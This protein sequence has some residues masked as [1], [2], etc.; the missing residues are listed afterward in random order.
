MYG[1]PALNLVNILVG[2]H[3]DL[4]QFQ[5]FASPLSQNGAFCD[6]NPAAGPESANIGDP[7]RYSHRQWI[8]DLNSCFGRLSCL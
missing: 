3:S 8:M 6:K 5:G 7:Q 4:P 2:Q 1:I